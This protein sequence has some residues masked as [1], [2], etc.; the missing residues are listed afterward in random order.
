VPP[1]VLRNKL[2]ELFAIDVNYMKIRKP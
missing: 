1:V 2:E